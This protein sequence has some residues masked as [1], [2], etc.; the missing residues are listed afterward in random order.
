MPNPKL[1]ELK[2]KLAAA[3]ANA[4]EAGPELTKLVTDLRQEIVDLKAANADPEVTDQEF[5][6]M[7]DELLGSSQELASIVPNVP[8]EIP[9]PTETEGGQPTA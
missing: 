9:P 4:R 2:P 1:S 5:T 6:T 8:P 3:L 7:V